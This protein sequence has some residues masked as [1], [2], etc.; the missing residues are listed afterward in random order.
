MGGAWEF[1]RGGKKMVTMGGL[2][3]GT[4]AWPEDVWRWAGVAG[5]T[6]NPSTWEA[7]ARRSAHSHL[8]SEFGSSLGHMIHYLKKT[9]RNC[10]ESPD[11]SHT[12]GVH[13]LWVARP[14]FLGTPLFCSAGCPSGRIV[15]LKCSGESYPVSRKLVV[16]GGESSCSPEGGK[17]VWRGLLRFLCVYL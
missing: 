5:C 2:K 14:S 12:L 3:V 6:C 11:H 9:K 1:V 17:A 15:S 4:T 7:V 16:G 13:G 8:Q 10:G